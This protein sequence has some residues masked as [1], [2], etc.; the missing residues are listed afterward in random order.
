MSPNVI[1]KIFY[2]PEE[3]AFWSKSQDQHIRV[4]DFYSHMSVSTHHFPWLVDEFIQR[5]CSIGLI[6]EQSPLRS[7]GDMT[8]SK[9]DTVY[10]FTELTQMHSWSCRNKEI[11][12]LYDAC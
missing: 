9:S 7:A 1:L 10:G 3:E 8:L 11:P 5:S 6:M 4:S 2:L 12:S